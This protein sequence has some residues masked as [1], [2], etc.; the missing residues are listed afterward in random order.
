M[1]G[2]EFTNTW[3]KCGCFGWGV[4][5]SCRKKQTMKQETR[6][7]LKEEVE[8]SRRKE[9]PREGPTLILN[10]ISFVKLFGRDNY[11]AS[12]ILTFDWSLI[13]SFLDIFT[14]DIVHFSKEGEKIVCLWIQVLDNRNED[15]DLFLWFLPLGSKFPVTTIPFH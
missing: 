9:M 10:I 3:M 15:L 13:W 1:D 6:K 8:W 11:A 12:Q 7:R 14:C 2:S 4:E 5:E